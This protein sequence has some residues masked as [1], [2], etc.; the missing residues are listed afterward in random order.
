MNDADDIRMRGW[1]Q[2]SFL[3]AADFDLSGMDTYLLISHPCDVVSS[4]FGRDPFVEAVPLHLVDG[5]DGNLTFGK[6]SRRLQIS[7]DGVVL[8][9][10]ATEKIV[11][12]RSSLIGKSP[13]DVLSE[14]DQRLLASWLSA[15]YARPAFADEFNRRMSSVSK[16]ISKVLK[17]Q[18]EH[19]SGIYVATSAAELDAD[20]SYQLTLVL[21]MLLDEFRDADLFVEAS[22]ACDT[23]AALFDE[24]TGI[25]LTSLELV[26]EDEMS[27]DALRRFRRWDYDDLSFRAGDDRTLPPSG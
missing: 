16:K 18:G 19:L 8:E 17:S 21:T 6:N 7:R 1:T 26:S 27:L 12:S 2:G 22:E 25:D 4:D 10:I 23:I 11:I 5:T 24:A 9:V 15:R 14:N 3:S 20:S 13:I